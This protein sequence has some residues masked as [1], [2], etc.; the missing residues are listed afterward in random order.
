LQADFVPFYV[1]WELF[2]IQRPVKLAQEFAWKPERNRLELLAVFRLLGY[3]DAIQVILPLSLIS[4]SPARTYTA[5][6]S[7][8]IGEH[9]RASL[10]HDRKM[11]E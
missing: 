2:F 10:K 1:F 6:W 8:A 4:S 3:A 11:F 7:L 9:L 5:L